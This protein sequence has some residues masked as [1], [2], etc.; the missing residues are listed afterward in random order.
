[1]TAP[2]THAPRRTPRAAREPFDLD[3]AAGGLLVDAHANTAGRA[4]R[5]LTPGC[6]STLT[7]TLIALVAGRGLARHVAPGPATIQVLRGSGVLRHDGHDLEL[8]PG[9]W[10]TIPTDPHELDATDDLVALLTVG[11]HVANA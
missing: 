3:A 11:G 4:A 1:M 9:T 5:N 2:T 10:A 8:H 7:Q 6:G